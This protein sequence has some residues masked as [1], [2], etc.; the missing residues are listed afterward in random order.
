VIE[1]LSRRQRIWD[2]AVTELGIDPTC[3]ERDAD[4]VASMDAWSRIARH[5]ESRG[6]ASESAEAWDWAV[7]EA[8]SD[9]DFEGPDQYVLW[10][11][12]AFY[13]RHDALGSLRA[14]LEQAW[15]CTRTTRPIPAEFAVR[16][17]ERLGVVY[18]R[19]M[20]PDRAAEV[21]ARAAVLTDLVAPRAASQDRRCA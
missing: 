19:M 14:T 3:L 20:M 7:S 17:L 8:L 10:E 21:Y 11:A 6:L 18:E 4:P 5:L 1:M 12:A 2:E 13:D 9:G 16:L 15:A